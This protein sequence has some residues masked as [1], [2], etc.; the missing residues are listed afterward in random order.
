MVYE[1]TTANFEGYPIQ[2]D[3]IGQ[4]YLRVQDTRKAVAE[5]IRNE[6]YLADN[7]DADHGR[8]NTGSARS[9]VFRGTGPTGVPAAADAGTT[10]FSKGRV[11]LSVT[12]A[13]LSRDYKLFVYEAAYGADAAGWKA[14]SYVNKTDAETVNGKKTFPT[15]PEVTDA[16]AF[17]SLAAN[18]LVK[19]SYIDAALT[20]AIATATA[21]ARDLL[22]PV[23]FRYAQM[24][25]APQ[26]GTASL[27]P[28]TNWSQVISDGS[29]LRID[30]GGA[31]AFNAAQQPENMPLHSHGITPAGSELAPVEY[32]ATPGA[33]YQP[34]GAAWQRYPLVAAPTTT[35][36]YGNAG[37]LRPANRT[38]Q[39][40][41]R[42][43]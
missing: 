34:S 35:E 13:E 43:S 39:I 3:K 16:T 25:G 10:D 31:A 42:I 14:L 28:G 9:F 36:S 15:A 41:E 11:A 37:E 6:H 24:P 33:D 18:D 26:P 32:S 17:A 4:V 7:L 8:H 12:G 23:G 19:K 22:I 38:I 30:G 2:T 21:N 29:F 20:A 5:R 40:W 27:W 1:W